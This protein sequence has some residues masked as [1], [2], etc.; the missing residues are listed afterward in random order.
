MQGALLHLS[1]DNLQLGQSSP[2]LSIAKVDEPY[3]DALLNRLSVENLFQSFW[4]LFLSNAPGIN[5]RSHG[6]KFSF[7]WND[8]Y[9]FHLL[10]FRQCVEGRCVEERWLKE[11]R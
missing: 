10:F 3:F 2:Q 9:S 11:V 5:P 8:S 4:W 6:G 1:Q 7:P